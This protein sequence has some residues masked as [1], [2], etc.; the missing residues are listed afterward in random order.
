MPEL[1]WNEYDF[2]ECLGVLPKIDEYETGHHFSVGKDGLNLVLSIWQ[3]D[4]LFEISL[5]QSGKDNP[6]INFYLSVREEVKFIN[7]KRGKYLSFQGCTIVSSEQPITDSI[8]FVQGIDSNNLVMQLEVDPQ[9][10][11]KFV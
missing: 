8:N 7:D 5:S 9:I 11:I 2:I 6:F 4:C 1:K 3:Y 10:Q